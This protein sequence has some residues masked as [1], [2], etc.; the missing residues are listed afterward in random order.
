[1]SSGCLGGRPSGVVPV[2]LAG[3]SEG[4]AASDGCTSLTDNTFLAGLVG[5]ADADSWPEKVGVR[6]GATL[7]LLVAAVGTTTGTA[8]RRIAT[9][10]LWRSFCRLRRRCSVS[11]DSCRLGT[12]RLAAAVAAVDELMLLDGLALRSTSAERR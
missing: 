5:A 8:L 4:G 3:A 9:V 2:T 1:M 7:G 6:L 12:V 10:W 11:L